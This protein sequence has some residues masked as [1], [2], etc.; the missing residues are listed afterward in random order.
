MA[1]TTEQVLLLNNLMYMSGD[2]LSICQAAKANHGMYRHQ[3][4]E[5][6]SNSSMDGE[7]MSRSRK[8]TFAS[9]SS[10]EL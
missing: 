8:S 1:L 2:A 7:R 4:F 9:A 3:T 10:T 5:C 6:K